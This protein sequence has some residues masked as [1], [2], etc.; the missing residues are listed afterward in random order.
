MLTPFIKHHAV[1][2]VSC[3]LFLENLF[4]QVSIYVQRLF[5]PKPANLWHNLVSFLLVQ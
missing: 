3:E 5:G 4:K 1:K 2:P